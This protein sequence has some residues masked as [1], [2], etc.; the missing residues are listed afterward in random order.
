M[1]YFLKASNQ[2]MRQM[3]IICKCLLYAI[4]GNSPIMLNEQTGKIKVTGLAFRI[5]IYEYYT[6]KENLKLRKP[7]LNPS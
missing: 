6:K 3:T 1:E 7:L 5:E 4:A 2:G